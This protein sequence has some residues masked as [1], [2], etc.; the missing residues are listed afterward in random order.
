MMIKPKYI[1]NVDASDFDK[2]T[3][4][5]LV[6]GNVV[7]SLDLTHSKEIKLGVSNKGYDD[8]L[9]SSEVTHNWDSARI[10]PDKR[11]SLNKGIQFYRL[12]FRYLKLACELEQMNV[13]LVWKQHNANIK[14]H[15]NPDIPRSVVEKSRYVDHKVGGNTSTAGI[16]QIF[17]K[18]IISKVKVNKRFYKDWHLDQVLTDRFDDWWK[19]H[20]HLFEGHH[21]SII[22]TKDEFVQDS[23]FVYVRLD[24]KTHWSDVQAYMRDVV[25]KEFE[26]T[27]KL[28]PKFRIS[29]KSPRVL[30]MQN[31]YNALV[32][33]LKGMSPEEICTHRNIYLRNT[34]KTGNRNP[35]NKRLAIKTE[36]GRPKYSTTVAVPYRMGLWHLKEVCEGRLGLSPDQHW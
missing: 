20:H 27:K 30:V 3:Y 35:N 16:H 2:K 6:K 26:A 25:S 15:T 5:A 11:G 13:S 32:L 4:D 21:P 28:K 14:D 19:T 1:A 29:G 36:K 10:S 34:D 17:R 18:K 9:H 12:W 31:A 23:D 24:K 8:I 7:E 33:K 22:K